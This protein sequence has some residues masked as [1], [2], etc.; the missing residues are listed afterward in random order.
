MVCYRFCQRNG[1]RVK[2]VNREN[3]AKREEKANA[4]VKLRAEL[5][6]YINENNVTSE[7]ILNMDE[8]ALRAFCLVLK[9]LHW[10]GD[11][12][13]TSQCPLNFCTLA[14]EVRKSRNSR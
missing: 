12:R 14:S 3:I 13:G 7:R 11:K 4:M 10:L 9:T 5:Q 1:L 2:A 8:V 6:A